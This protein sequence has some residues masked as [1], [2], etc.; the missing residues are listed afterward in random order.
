M[1]FGLFILATVT[2]FIRPGEVIP[3]LEGAPI[4][5]ILILGCLVV[6]WPRVMQTLANVKKQPITLCV[7]GLWVAGLL[8]H[9]ARFDTFS[10]RTFAENFGR[11]VIY[12][13][14]LVSLIDS[15]TR[16][17]GFQAWT[18]G[19]IT[20]MSAVAV[21]QYHGVINLPGLKVLEQ[22]QFDAET[23]DMVIVPRLCGSGI[24]NDPNDLCLAL[25]MG[26]VFGLCWLCDKRVGPMRFL[27]L[28]ALLLFVYTL[29][30]TQSR[31]GLLGF[32]IALLVLCWTRFG[33]RKVLPPAVIL[34]P[35]MILLMGGRQA[36]FNIEGGDTG[37][38][39]LQ[40]WSEGLG[41][42]RQSPLFGIGT[43]Q[44]VE[45]VGYV[46]HNSFVHAFTEMGFFGGSLFVGAFYL[47][48]WPLAFRGGEQADGGDEEYRRLRPFT[49]ALVAGYAGGIWSLSRVYVE[50]TYLVLALAQAHLALVGSAVPFPAWRPGLVKRLA[51]V[52]AVV[53]AGLY[54]MIRSTISYG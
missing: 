29:R 47:A 54:V 19:A 17:R 50:V 32:S 42:F 15:A 25:T 26:T 38:S 21:L 43:G 13:I 39:R 36:N 53:L 8:S 2:L 37:Q 12:F 48:L 30:L 24:F 14:L 18:L 4:Y 6:S 10:A 46:A 28:P 20:L 45:E 33:W 23:G 35:G 22:R 40:L 5:Q 16:L 31:G 44:Y 27:C 9:L 11:V 52:G 51:C 49:L 41:L 34:I 7:L 1:G 3:D